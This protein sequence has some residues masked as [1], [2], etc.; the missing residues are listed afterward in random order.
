MLN[1]DSRVRSLLIQVIKVL[2]NY[3]Y[4]ETSGNQFVDMRI[5]R[6]L[7]MLLFDDE[8]EIK[9]SLLDILSLG[10]EITLTIE[11]FNELLNFMSHPNKLIR[12][13]ISKS[14]SVIILHSNLN[15]SNLVNQII[16]IY[17]QALPVVVAQSNLR[18]SNDVV[19]E[20]NDL[21]S[22]REKLLAL[23][24]S[25]KDKKNS[26]ILREK[27]LMSIGV[28]KTSQSSVIISDSKKTLQSANINNSVNSILP[29]KL[30]SR[31][32]SE[33]VINPYLNHTREC[34]ANVFIHIGSHNSLNSKI[35]SILDN[36]HSSYVKDIV[37]EE[38]FMQIF[39]FITQFGVV[40]VDPDVRLHMMNAGYYF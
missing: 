10:K 15:K 30:P 33:V 20:E 39:E 24:G 25:G 12:N 26:S 1:S 19:T 16:N 7:L 13:M 23:G 21:K 3:G 2:L 14:L 4:L 40:D 34:I 5:N 22:S 29:P 6:S 28:K 11:L 38:F 8:D 17:S 37:S 31:S 36:K 32:R 9:N 27:D 35:L 18:N